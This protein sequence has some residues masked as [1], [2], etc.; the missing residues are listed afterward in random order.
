VEINI[1]SGAR[2]YCSCCIADSTLTGLVPFFAPGTDKWS[3]TVSMAL[4]VFFATHIYGLKA[5]GI[6]YI[7]HFLSPVWPP[8]VIFII[9]MPIYLT[10]E[11][12]GHFARVLSLSIRLMANMMADHMVVGI[13]LMLIGPI[14]PVFFAGMGV[15]VCLMQAFI[16]SVLTMIYLGLATAHE[17][18]DE[19][20]HEAAH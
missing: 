9:M 2:R 13:F 11:L 14:I 12:I 1:I 5:A 7:T 20:G 15:I 10:I 6:S 16:F 3:I 8:N 4:V 17:G 19:E 18:H